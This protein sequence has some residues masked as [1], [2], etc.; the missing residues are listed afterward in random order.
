VLVVRAVEKWLAANAREPGQFQPN[1]MN[2]KEQ[3]N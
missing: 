2:A 3:E 1:A